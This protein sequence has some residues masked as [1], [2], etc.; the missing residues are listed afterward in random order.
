MLTLDRKQQPLALCERRRF[1]PPFLAG[2]LFAALALVPLGASAPFTPMRVL[3]LSAL[4][5]AALGLGLLGRPRTRRR[6]LP[7]R[8]PG[9][10]ERYVGLVL[11]GAALPPTYRAVLVLADGTRR[12]VLE[13]DEPAGVLEDAALLA[14]ELGVAITA[15]W[16]LDERTLATLT[17]PHEHAGPRWRSDGAFR[18]DSPP[19]AGQRNAAWTT[20]WASAFVLVATIAMSDTARARVTPGLLSIT[21]PTL[22]VLLV[23]VVW[24]WLLGLRGE[25]ELDATGVTRRTHWFRVALGPARRVEMPV[26]AAAF[27]APEGAEVGHLV[28]SDGVKLVA[29]PLRGGTQQLAR[30]RDALARE[31]TNRAAE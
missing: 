14:R 23:L 29:F 4:L 11:E 24:L 13:R 27:V 26:V 28:V 19:L 16:G 3:G 25:L 30:L 21:L 5:A 1:E 20:L 17:H 18:F 8:T 12:P 22:S 15:G 7:S 6:P 10:R 2:I 9:P 31:R